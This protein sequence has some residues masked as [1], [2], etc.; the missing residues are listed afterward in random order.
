MALNRE[1]AL[2]LKKWEGDNTD[3]QLIGLAQLLQG[4]E[5]LMG[6]VILSLVSRSPAAKI[7]SY[8]ILWSLSCNQ[9]VFFAPD[10]F[11]RPLV[12]LAVQSN[13]YYPTFLI[14]FLA[15][16]PPNNFNLAGSREIFFVFLRIEP[17]TFLS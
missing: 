5:N 1:N 16:M 3:R 14:L 12:G 7:R 2:L 10:C 6:R 17:R 13:E 4:P 9:L 11:F 8:L 15:T